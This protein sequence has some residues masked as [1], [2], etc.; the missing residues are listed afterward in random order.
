MTTGSVI[1]YRGAVT[2]SANPADPDF[3]TESAV[4]PWRKPK[5]KK[6]EGPVRPTKG[7]NPEDL[8]LFLTCLNTLDA[9]GGTA[10]ASLRACLAK[11]GLLAAGEEFPAAWTA[12]ARRAG[13]ALRALIV[14]DAGGPVDE[15]ALQELSRLASE[16]TIR[17][18]FAPD[19]TTWLEP[20]AKGLD[21]VVDR[22]L[23]FV[24][25]A[26]FE[27]RW[28]RVKICG[29][30]ACRHVFYDASRNLV[31]RWCSSRCGNRLRSRHGRRPKKPV[32]W[33]S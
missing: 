7:P 5:R 32:K 21:G 10:F 30:P 26:R 6:R 20:A 19:A 2:R 9:G 18:G 14:A 16:A 24:A 17:P 28:P 8:E 22:L 12:R 27:N 3:D 25:R 11:L 23:A 4:Y 13:T 29:D 1:C 15:P 33:S 31:G